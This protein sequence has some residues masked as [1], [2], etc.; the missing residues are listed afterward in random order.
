M[1][2]G[3]A[4][5]ALSD[6]MEVLLVFGLPVPARGSLLC[7]AMVSKEQVVCGDGVSLIASKALQCRHERDKIPVGMDCDVPS[8]GGQSH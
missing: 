5:K 4:W 3:V 7:C 1:T 2:R 6:S 8:A